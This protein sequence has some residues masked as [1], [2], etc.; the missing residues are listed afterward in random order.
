ME[1]MTREKCGRIGVL[2][3]TAQVRP[4]AESQAKPYSG[5]CAT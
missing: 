1:I 2:P 4:W 5:E 3:C